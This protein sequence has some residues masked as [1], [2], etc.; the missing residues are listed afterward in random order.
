MKQHF[1]FR[2][3]G[4]HLLRFREVGGLLTPVD[5]VPYSIFSFCLQVWT[6]GGD[7]LCRSLAGKGGGWPS[8]DHHRHTCTDSS[9]NGSPRFKF[10][11]SGPESCI[12]AYYV[13]QGWKAGGYCAQTCNLSESKSRKR[14]IRRMIASGIASTDTPIFAAGV[15]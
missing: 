1:N 7:P 15:T 13:M 14:W 12:V 4:S 8:R 10:S 5:V 2:V 3:I 6:G 9:N 11:T